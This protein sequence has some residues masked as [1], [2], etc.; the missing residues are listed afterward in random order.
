M[1][2]ALIPTLI[3]IASLLGYRQA[4]SQQPANPKA[5]AMELS[6]AST[7]EHL[8]TAIIAIEATED[9]LVKSILLGYH[10]AAQNHLKAAAEEQGRRAH[11]E[12]AATEIGNVA[13]EGDKRIRAVRQRLA[14]A[15]HTHNTDAVTKEDYMFIDSKEKKELLA[16]AQRVG[17]LGAQGKA[18]EI[19]SASDDLRALFDRAIAAE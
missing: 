19:S 9:E 7:Y 18:A 17:Q 14:Q 3:V 4:T 2:K 13:N 11:L 1:K 12:S 15:G 10:A 6:A 5:E 8:A 16:L